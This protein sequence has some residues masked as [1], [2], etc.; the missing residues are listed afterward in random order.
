MK[1]IKYHPNG[2]RLWINI[3]MKGLYYVSYTFQMWSASTTEPPILTNPLKNGN[4]D[5][6]HDDYYPIVNDYNTTEPLSQYHKRTLEIRL[7][8]KKV[9]GDDGYHLRAV[10]YQG[11]DFESAEELGYDEVEDSL[12][13][14]GIKIESLVLKLK[15]K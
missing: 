2:G 3:E 7:L 14:A 8:I 13:G 4:N 6:P 11:N 1:T 9:K 15:K 5:S 12:N 10:V